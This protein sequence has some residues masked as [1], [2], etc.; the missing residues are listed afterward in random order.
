MGSVSSPLKREESW[1]PGITTSRVLSGRES[2]A[3][4]ALA[5]DGVR[6]P[7]H[8]AYQWAESFEHV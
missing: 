8:T 6:A 4:I 5:S 2:V 3:L 1:P 7:E